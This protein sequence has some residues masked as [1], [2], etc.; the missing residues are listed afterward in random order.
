MSSILT[1]SFN[2]DFTA[3]STINMSLKH[4]THED[5]HDNKDTLN[6]KDR[7]LKQSENLDRAD[8]LKNIDGEQQSE[9]NSLKVQDSVLEEKSRSV[10]IS[11][12]E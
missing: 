8:S 5:N 6:S 10:G 12:K 3:V 4:V 11:T 7:L 9:Q 2:S 1:S